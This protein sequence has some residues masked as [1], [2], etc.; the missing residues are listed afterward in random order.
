MA[1]EI[2]FESAKTKNTNGYGQNTN[3]G[4]FVQLRTLIKFSLYVGFLCPT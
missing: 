4:D 2:S 3:F 1:L